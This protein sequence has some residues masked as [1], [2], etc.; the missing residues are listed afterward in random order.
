MGNKGKVESENVPAMRQQQSL[1]IDL[2]PLSALIFQ[3]MHAS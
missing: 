1:L 2:P 3:T